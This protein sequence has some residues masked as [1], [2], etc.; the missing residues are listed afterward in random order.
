M[1][2]LPCIDSSL[3]TNC[4]D[5]RFMSTK[6]GNT[7]IRKLAIVSTCI[8]MCIAAHPASAELRTYLRDAELGRENVR[9]RLAPTYLG[10]LPEHDATRWSTGCR[11][12]TRSLSFRSG[13]DLYDS[14][15]ESWSGRTLTDR[16]RSPPM[17][18]I[19]SS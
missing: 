2:Y 14:T 6:A 7:V 15:A 11:S 10:R 16:A 17:A 12:G 4:G 1:R 3:A 5:R 13:F 8:S 9:G 18:N 19:R